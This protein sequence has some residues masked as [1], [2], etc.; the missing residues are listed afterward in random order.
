[1]S[2]L[3][4]LNELIYNLLILLLCIWTLIVFGIKKIRIKLLGLKGTTN[5]ENYNKCMKTDKFR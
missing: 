4:D 2:T 1:M 5:K 3:F